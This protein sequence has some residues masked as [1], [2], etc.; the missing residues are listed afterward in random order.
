[1]KYGKKL[2]DSLHS[3]CRCKKMLLGRQSVLFAQTER[4][5][6][7]HS[8]T[9]VVTSIPANDFTTTSVSSSGRHVMAFQNRTGTRFGVQFHPEA[10]PQNHDVLRRFVRHCERRRRWRRRVRHMWRAVAAALR[11]SG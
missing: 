4:I 11:R 2:L 1:M 5:A 10:L 7:R 9:D 3:A 6:T 8:H